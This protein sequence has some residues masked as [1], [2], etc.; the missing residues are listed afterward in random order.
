MLESLD[1][2]VR[3]LARRLFPARFRY[4]LRILAQARPRREQYVRRMLA[5]QDVDIR[6]VERLVQPSDGVVIDVGAEEGEMTRHFAERGFRVLAFEP[7][8]RNAIALLSSSLRY[9]L[10]G[11]VHVFR[12]ACSNFDGTAVLDTSGPS[13][14]YSLRS[15]QTLDGEPEELVPVV[16]LGSW[17]VEQGIKEVAFLKVDAEGSDYDVLCGYWNHA[18]VPPPKVVMFEFTRGELE[19]M[20]DL[21]HQKGYRHFRFICRWNE[22]EGQESQIRWLVADGVHPLI[23]D[24][25]WGNAICS[26]VDPRVLYPLKGQ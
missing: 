8:R 10:T 14:A 7:S 22:V 18:E 9:V 19:R 15:S 20:L 17:L 1:I 5:G 11:R 2:C 21:M 25:E 6:E 13:W 4:T 12:M 23:F 16:R 3:R 26:T 24:A